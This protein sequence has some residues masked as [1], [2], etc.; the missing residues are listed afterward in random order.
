MRLL[1][2][3]D[4]YE[5]YKYPNCAGCLRKVDE[6]N[7]VLGYRYRCNDGRLCNGVVNPADNTWFSTLRK[8]EEP[9]HILRSLKPCFSL[10]LYWYLSSR[11][12]D[13]LPVKLHESFIGWSDVSSHHLKSITWTI[14]SPTSS[15]GSRL[16]V[17][18]DWW[19]FGSICRETGE[20]F[21]MV[22]PDHTKNTL[23][24]LMASQIAAG[25]TVYTN[26]AATYEDITG[27]RMDWIH[28]KFNHRK[29]FVRYVLYRGHVYIVHTNTTEIVATY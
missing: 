16:Y 28:L 11:R 25:S 23:W 29:Q 13:R 1:V 7:K 18:E 5:L 15:S 21:A 8:T 12:T 17:L 20:C 4:D 26:S 14:G 6:Q 2:L 22:V 19:M 10:V 24:P 27:L 9:N 3:S